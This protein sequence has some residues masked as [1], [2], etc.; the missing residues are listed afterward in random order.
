MSA[1]PKP[2]H[3]QSSG[4]SWS[5]KIGSEWMSP[6]LYVCAARELDRACVDDA[7]LGDDHDV[8]EE[9]GAAMDIYLENA[10]PRPRASFRG[11]ASPAVSRPIWIDGRAPAPH[12]RGR[13]PRNS[14]GQTLR[15]NLRAL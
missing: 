13:P 11:W 15:D 12:R 10:P 7:L 14:S 6:E 2:F 8:A 3:V 1:A 9:S 5:G 4:E